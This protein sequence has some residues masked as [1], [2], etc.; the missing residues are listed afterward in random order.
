MITETE[1]W[2]KVEYISYKE[3]NLVL[4]YFLKNN[5]CD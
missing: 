3:L 4:Y 1:K 5:V 2:K